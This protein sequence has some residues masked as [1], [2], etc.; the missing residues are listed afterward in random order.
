MKMGFKRERQVNH[1][2]WPEDSEFYGLEVYA[3]V[4]SV[5]SELAVLAHLNEIEHSKVTAFSIVP[6][7]TAFVADAIGWNVEYPDDSRV[8]LNLET[9]L[10]YDRPFVTAICTAWRNQ[11]MEHIMP[12]PVAVDEEI[13]TQDEDVFIDPD[14][15]LVARG[16]KALDIPEPVDATAVA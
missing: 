3:L 12:A 5:T 4:D 1:F 9:L 13:D 14:D 6:L 15:Q 2:T 8:P 7:A 11:V 10:G 16:L